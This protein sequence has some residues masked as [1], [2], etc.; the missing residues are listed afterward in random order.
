M[1]WDAGESELYSLPNVK[2]EKCQYYIEDEYIKPIPGSKVVRYDPF[3]YYTP[4]G[5]DEAQTEKP[6]W[7]ELADL[8]IYKD[9]EILNFIN[10]YGLL[11]LAGVRLG[12]LPMEFNNEIYYR[13]GTSI[14]PIDE[15]IERYKV[16]LT[17]YMK[18]HPENK[19]GIFL[20]FHLSS[21]SLAELK[22][23]INE[24]QEAVRSYI[25]FQKANIQDI[26][27]ALDPVECQ[28]IYGSH[29]IYRLID[30]FRSPILKYTR[31]V[32]PVLMPHPYHKNK[33]TWYWYYNSLVS[34]IYLMLSMVISGNWYV[35][36]CANEKCRQ[37]FATDVHNKFHCCTKCGWAHRKR[38][39]RK[40]KK[41]GK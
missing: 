21:E 10:K 28:K 15:L 27:K 18:E 7:I 11:G 9:N 6:I 13:F 31:Y 2:W 33:F 26:R 14:R 36:H 22:S 23:V 39:S 19:T 38:E 30:N 3:L 17:S 35:R 12:D 25:A 24:Y 5:I 1:T 32:R 34:A 29:E 40:S 8:K 20:L 37:I 4:P 41:E 16:P